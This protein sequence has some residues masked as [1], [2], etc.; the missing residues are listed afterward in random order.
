MRQVA[1]WPSRKQSPKSPD[2][3]SNTLGCS[4]LKD[5]ELRTC[6]TSSQCLWG[7]KAWHVLEF[8]KHGNISA[9][10]YHCFSSAQ[11][12]PSPPS[13]GPVRPAGSKPPS[14]TFLFLRQ[15]QQVL[16]DV[17]QALYLLLDTEFTA[18]G[19]P[20]LSVC[21]Q[22]SILHGAETQVVKRGLSHLC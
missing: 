10:R 14:P 19:D 16:E 8:P 17:H 18:H 7:C 20:K 12:P 5:I 13:P 6:N 3:L 2:P 1:A 9:F 4:A 15:P 11:S 21:F 22:H